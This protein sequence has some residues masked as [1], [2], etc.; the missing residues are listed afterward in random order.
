M[1]I[2]GVIWDYDGTLVD[3]EM[4]NL[5]VTKA[6]LKEILRIP[7]V[8][9]SALDSIEDYEH[10]NTKSSN[11]RNLYR[12]ELGLNEEQIDEA[13]KLWTRF[14]L[15][16]NTEIRFFEGISPVVKEL[17]KYS[18]GIVSQNS[19]ENIRINL[20]RAGL[21]KYF[22]QIIGYEEVGLTEQKP[23]P[24]GLLKCISKLTNQKNT[25]SVVYI[26]DHITDIECAQNANKKVNRNLVTSILL[27]NNKK[28]FNGGWDYKPDYTADHPEDIPRIIE[29]IKEV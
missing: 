28:N 4:K 10:A 16:D 8:K 9:Y 22:H 19:S 6:I 18:Q 13:G 25:G 21:A 17:S 2:I 14:Q 5:N 24:E 20:E 1:N 23:N 11:W 7:D 27:K 12:N 26:G 3:T 15:L 29:K